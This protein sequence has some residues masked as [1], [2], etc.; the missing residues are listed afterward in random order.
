MKRGFSLIEIM[1]VV[2]ILAS[3]AGGIYV[4]YSP[5]GTGITTFTALNPYLSKPVQDMGRAYK[6][7]GYAV[8]YTEPSHTNTKATFDFGDGNK[9]LEIKWRTMNYFI[10]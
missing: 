2:F 9:T 5:D 6:T 7:T 8:Y 3:L 1:I 10:W 4:V